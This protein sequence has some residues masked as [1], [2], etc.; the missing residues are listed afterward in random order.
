MLVPEFWAEARKQHRDGKR[1]LTVRRFGWSN[2]SQDEALAMAELRAAEA[3]SRLLAGEKIERREPKIAYNGADGVP[4]REEVLS[5]HGEEVV[6]RNAYGAHCLNTP[7][8]LFADIDFDAPSRAREVLLVL[9]LMAGGS[10]LAGLYFHRWEVVLI[11]LLLSLSLAF[12]LA[13]LLCRLLIAWRGG[14]ERLARQRV[15]TFLARHPDWNLRLYTTPNGLRLLATHRPFSADEPEVLQ[16]FS[17]VGTDPVYVRMCLNQRCFRAR[18]TAKPWRIGIAAHL[19]PRPGVWPV[20]PARLPLRE[21]WVAEYESKAAEFA[22]CR[23]VESLGSGKV[24]RDLRPV[25]EL[26]DRESRADRRTLALA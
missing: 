17:A 4:I 3:L 6:T 8:A 21:Q 15:L 13:S 18:L 23:F 24:H 1:Q 10:V 20:D 9:V 11:L 25:I 12:P 26:H 19:R 2:D 22:A 16:F 5:R 14:P 7:R